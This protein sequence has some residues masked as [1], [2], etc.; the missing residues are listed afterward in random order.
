MFTQ[1]ILPALLT[2]AAIFTYTAVSGSDKVSS[3]TKLTKD[4]LSLVEN[5]LKGKDLNIAKSSVDVEAYLIDG[6][7]F[8]SLR[9]VMNG[10]PGH[11]KLVEGAESKTAYEQLT[12]TDD[13]SAGYMVVKTQ[14]PRLGERFHSVVFFADSDKHWKIRSWH[15]SN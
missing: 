4:L 5:I 1:R 11:C 6:T 13:R 15:I 9:G 7:H 14:T 8:E 3:D 12:I 2:I 10:E